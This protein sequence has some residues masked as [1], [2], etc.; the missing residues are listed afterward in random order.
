MT[1]ASA[2]R[3]AGRGGALL[4]ALALAGCVSNPPAEKAAGP[5]GPIF[6]PSEPGAGRVQHLATFTGE[7]DVKGPEGGFAKFIAGDDPATQQFRQPY[8]VSLRDGKLYVV[9][10][11]APGLAELDLRG[12]QYRLFSGTGGGRMRRPINV[13]FDERGTRYV[14]DTARNQI[15]VY[16]ADDR[17]LA[18]HGGDDAYKP[19]D[20]AVSGNRLYV[21]DIQNHRIVVLDRNTGKELSAFGKPGSGPGELFHPTNLALAP[22]GD[23]LVVDTSNYRIQRFAPD[24]RFLGGFGEVGNQPGNFSRPKGIAIDRTGLVYVADAA[25]EN[26]QIFTPEGRLLLYFGQPEDGR[27]GLNLPAGVAID[28]ENVDLFRGHAAP[29]FDIDYLVLVTSQFGPN[30]VDVFGFGRQRGQVVGDAAGT[31]IQAGNR[32][33]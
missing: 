26:V 21:A 33:P 30:K 28:Y 16:G 1:S 7:R 8:G 3:K 27:E 29:G 20:V 17:F 19:V 15:L 18:A 9:D 14:T 31:E 5:S 12:R 6:Y 4:F 25:F 22:N 13:S 24:G 32:R 2:W 11:R 23:V 10:S